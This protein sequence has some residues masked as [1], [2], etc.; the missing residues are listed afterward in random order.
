MFLSRT[1]TSHS[2]KED[3]AESFLPETMVSLLSMS[4]VT[5]DVKMTNPQWEDHGLS[6]ILNAF[7]LFLL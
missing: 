1:L 4:R 5:S 2:K 3:S 6:S 7:W